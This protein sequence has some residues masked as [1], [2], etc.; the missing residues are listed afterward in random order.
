MPDQQA[1]ML[2]VD[3][4]PEPVSLRSLD[5][6]EPKPERQKRAT[7]VNQVDLDGENHKLVIRNGQVILRKKGKRHVDCKSVVEVAQFVRGQ[8][9]LFNTLKSQPSEAAMTALRKIVAAINDGNYEIDVNTINAL[10]EAE[11]LLQ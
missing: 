4:G 9:D 5:I 8:G 2:G 7:G 11:K 3:P 1:M 6:P 10:G